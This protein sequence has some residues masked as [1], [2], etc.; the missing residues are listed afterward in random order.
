MPAP[1]RGAK[2]FLLYIYSPLFH[3]EKRKSWLVNKLL[4]EYYKKKGL[5]IKDE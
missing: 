2:K 1:N 3:R 4:D 5:H